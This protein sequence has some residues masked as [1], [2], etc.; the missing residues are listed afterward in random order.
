MF[1]P[2][3]LIITAQPIQQV[4]GIYII[5]CIANEKCY[6]GSSISIKTRIMGHKSK[7]NT[8]KH[9]NSHLQKS[10]EKYGKQN[11]IFR[12][13]E[14]FPGFTNPQLLEPENKYLLN[15]DRELLFNQA[16]PATLRNEK[17]TRGQTS[18]IN[19]EKHPQSK[20]TKELA[21]KIKAD[22]DKLVKP[23]K[24]VTGIRKHLATKYN[25]SKHL[26]GAIGTGK[27][28]TNPNYV[29]SNSAK[30]K[31]LSVKGEL[32]QKKGVSEKIKISKEICK[33]IYKDWTEARKDIGDRAF[34]PGLT[35]KLANKYDVGIDTIRS[36][37]SGKHPNS[38]IH[39]KKEKYHIESYTS[40][41]EPE[42]ALKII[43]RHEE[44]RKERGK[45]NIVGIQDILAKE[46]SV[47]LRT[48]RD[49]YGYKFRNGM[50]RPSTRKYQ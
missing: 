9:D 25:L 7:L 27:H 8:G 14:T 15:I 33:K 5:Y 31:K 29:W 36:I 45:R 2:K 18:K 20:V 44:I 32:K 47:P 12:V 3:E 4:A 46:F 43:N 41:I 26:V 39:Q 6:I 50:C 37:A 19:G 34:I 23:G 17:T 1:T 35:T 11:F 30:E 16:I 49:A 28:W 40:A 10:W 24:F 13:L 38:P 21:L 48:I 22:Y 42:L